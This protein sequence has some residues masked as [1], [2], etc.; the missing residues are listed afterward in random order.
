MPFV[1]QEFIK[2]GIYI[3]FLTLVSYYWVGSSL[4]TALIVAL[5]S[6]GVLFVLNFKEIRNRYKAIKNILI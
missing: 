3:F 5:V 2:A 1:L 4:S 6:Q